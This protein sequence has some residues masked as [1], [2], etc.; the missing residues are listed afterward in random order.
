MGGAGEMA[1]QLRALAALLEDPGSVASTRMAAHNCLN[2]IA[3]DPTLSQK[4]AGQTPVYIKVKK[5]IKK[6]KYAKRKK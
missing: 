3:G 6:G 1:Q 2:S 5:N 4:L